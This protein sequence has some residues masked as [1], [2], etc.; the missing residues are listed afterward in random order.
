[1]I[2]KLEAALDSFDPRVRVDALERLIELAEAGRIEL[3]PPAKSVNIHCHTFFSFNTYGYSPTKFAWLARRGGLAVAGIADFDVLD[4]LEEFHSACA[5]L[6]LK[7]VVGIETRVFIPEFAD[8]EINS[9]GEPGISYHM[10][11][12]MPSGQLTG[13]PAAFLRRLK[14][15]AQERNLASMARVNA[16][17]SPVELDYEA[18]VAPLTPAGNPTERHLCT[19]YARKA[20]AMFPS[21]RDLAEYWR[22]KLG[23][24]VEG[25][26]LPEG[27]KLLNMIRQK[28]MKQGGAGYVQ[29]DAG[30]FPTIEAMNR[31][32]LD[33]GGIPTHTWLNGMSDG[34]REIE[35]LLEVA[36][37]T[38]AEAI[39]VIPDRNYAPGVKDE[40]LTNLYAVVALAEK[41]D[42]P[43]VMG[44]EMNSPGQKF[45][46]D[47]DSA[48]LRPLAA[49]FLKGAHI[50]YGHSALQRAAA[51]GYTSAWAKGHF[52]DR[53]A[54]NAF[55]V[56]VGERINA[57]PPADLN[58]EMTPDEILKQ[59][60]K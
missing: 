18:D 12:G 16:Y 38:G 26:G 15:T 14:E 4:G 42:L 24:E 9:P 11:V 35:R 22:V 60:E 58:A 46:D 10:G 40:K 20:R 27:G 19:A 8:K 3:A 48:E 17:L 32:L 29:P 36:M 28:T 1:M 13:E 5:R 30:A 52:A 56:A 49:I 43:V 51:M 37:S 44:T 57:E 41:L 45:V 2:D 54:K 39:N 25:L 59:L 47:F 34:E 7:G 6:G 31:F 55:Y 33:A 21:D 53:A 50:V 23:V